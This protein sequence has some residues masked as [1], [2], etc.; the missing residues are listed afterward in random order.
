MLTKRDTITIVLHAIQGA[1][2]GNLNV[3]KAIEGAISDG[4]TPTVDATA[5]AT[6]AIHLS[7]I[8]LHD[9]G[10]TNLV[11]TLHTENAWR[12]LTARWNDETEQTDG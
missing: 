2:D 11:D 10:N 12:A 4:D 8:I 9:A 3:R 1:L 5:I 6:A 7:A